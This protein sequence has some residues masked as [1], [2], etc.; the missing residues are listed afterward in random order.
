MCELMRFLLFIAV[1][2]LN[3]KC[4]GLSNAARS[5]CLSLAAKSSASGVRGN[6]F[7]VAVLDARIEGIRGL[8]ISRTMIGEDC[9]SGCGLLANGKLYSLMRLERSSL[10]SG[11]VTAVALCS[12]SAH[13]QW[14]CRFVFIAVGAQCPPHAAV[15]PGF[16][17]W[18]RCRFPGYRCG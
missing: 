13:T 10:A 4:S 14:L 15:F 7:P 2:V 12:S 5:S 11:S 6:L 18:C 8:G 3:R 1:F 17:C 9:L 16:E